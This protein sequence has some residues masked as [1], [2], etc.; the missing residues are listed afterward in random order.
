MKEYVMMIISVAAICGVLKILLPARSVSASVLFSMRVIIIL[1]VVSPV[2]SFMSSFSLEE[3]DFVIN[4][5]TVHT[6]DSEDAE[7]LWRRWLANDTAEKM[8]DEI[9]GKILE[10]FNLSVEVT[11]P[12]HEEGQDVVFDQIVI[13]TDCDEKKQKK[14]EDYVLIWYSLKSECVSGEKDG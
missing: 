5:K 8:A 14:I 6:I 4:E 12:W 7:I 1:I 11:V 2:F 10:N 9:E 3:K 13:R